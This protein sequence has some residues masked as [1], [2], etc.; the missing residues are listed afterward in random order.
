MPKGFSRF[1]I[2]LMILVLVIV[3]AGSY[4]FQSLLSAYYLPVFPWLLGFFVVVSLVVH[5]FHLKAQEGDSKKFPRYS[6]AVNGIKIFLY[7]IVVVGYIFLR[8]ESAVPFLF[9]FFA[10]Y[11]LFSVYETMMFYKSKSTS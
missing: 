9:G 6:M 1:V 10:L 3:L 4:L 5:F 7:L 2:G 11:L 8:R